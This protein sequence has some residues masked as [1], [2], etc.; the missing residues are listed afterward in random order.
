MISLKDKQVIQVYSAVGYTKEKPR[1]SNTIPVN[2]PE[3][4]PT[5]PQDGSHTYLNLPR[6]YFAN[7]NFP[8]AQGSIMLSHSVELPLMNGCS[9]PTVFEKGT[10]FTLIIPTHKIESGY[11]IYVG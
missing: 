6:K 5:I 4:L 10:K 3:V 8:I 7:S 11:L 2:I 1:I 9:C